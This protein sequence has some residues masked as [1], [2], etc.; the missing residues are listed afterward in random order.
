[1]GNLNYDLVYQGF[2]GGSTYLEESTLV[3]MF[4]QLALALQHLHA[5]KVQ[6]NPQTPDNYM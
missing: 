1:M 2:S 6:P 3:S 5:H 4:C